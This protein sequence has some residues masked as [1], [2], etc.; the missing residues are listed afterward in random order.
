M[1]AMNAALWFGSI[2]AA[3]SVGVRV[4][5]VSKVEKKKKLHEREMEDGK[6][7]R[8]SN[9]KVV[10]RK[11]NKQTSNERRKKRQQ[12]QDGVRSWEKAAVNE[13]KR[14]NRLKHPSQTPHQPHFSLTP[15]TPSPSLASQAPRSIYSQCSS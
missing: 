13:E 10:S 4:C 12:E 2:F 1:G 7:G 6:N 3:A 14:R 8:K 11:R 5:V 15:T 9:N